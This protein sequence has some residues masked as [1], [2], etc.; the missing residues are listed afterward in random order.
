MRRLG[1]LVV[2]VGC[3]PAYDGVRLELK[4][5]APDG[6]VV[7][8]EAL[9]LVEGVP[10]LISGEVQ[11]SKSKAYDRE[12]DTF[13]LESDDEAIV[14]VERTDRAWEFVIVGS[15]VGETC[16]HVVVDGDDMECIPAS[17]IAQ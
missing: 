7:S 10:L 15:M 14:T 1:L 12:D 11:S 6:T 4:D 9:V 3:K 16:V 13:E 8:G 17:V 2:L 5:A